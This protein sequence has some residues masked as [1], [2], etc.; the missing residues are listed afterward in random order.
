M[1]VRG[2][3]LWR[4][5]QSFATAEALFKLRR[6][7]PPGFVEPSTEAAFEHAL[8]VR[9]ANPT[10]SE[11]ALEPLFAAHVLSPS[12]QIVS[13][14]FAPHLIEGT[15]TYVSRDLRDAMALSPDVVNYRPVDTQL[16]VG[17]SARRAYAIIEP[18]MS[19]DPVDHL[20]SD[21]QPCR[22]LE[23]EAGGQWHPVVDPNAPARRIR[24]RGGF[25]PP[26]P[27]F[28]MAGPIGGGLVVSDQLAEGVIAADIDD[29][30]F[31]KI[32]NEHGQ[33]DLVY[34]GLLRQ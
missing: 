10:L 31:L 30:I 25:T 17:P 1:T 4:M 19:A 8:A 18:A 2:P 34:K 33:T 20:A 3:P 13:A 27:L 6:R 29:L 15:Y 23:G 21:P 14:T 26:A 16:C 32:D 22:W 12:L 5:H 7:H 28:A 24:L 11:K 9:E